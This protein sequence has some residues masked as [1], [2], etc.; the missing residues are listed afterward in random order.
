MRKRRRR[1]KAEEVRSPDTKQRGGRERRETLGRGGCVAHHRARP[2]VVV[3]VL[4][5]A[6]LWVEPR[7][8]PF[9]GVRVGPSRPPVVRSPERRR[10]SRQPRGHVAAIN[11]QRSR[12]CKCWNRS[13]RIS[14]FS[15]WWR[16]RPL[17]NIGNIIVLVHLCMSVHGQASGVFLDN[18][19][20]PTRRFLQLSQNT[21]PAQS[22]LRPHS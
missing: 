11:A 12:W 3:P 1:D 15:F 16:H 14:R 18:Q 7:L 22:P 17:T 6:R 2:V 13:W 21:P 4:C 9:V 10:L 19:L 20:R 5:V 8:G